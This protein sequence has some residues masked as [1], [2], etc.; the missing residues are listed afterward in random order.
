MGPPILLYN[1]YRVSFP[2]VKR[3]G[4]G[5]DHIPPSSAQVKENVELYLYSLS[6]LSWPVLLP[7]ILVEEMCYYNPRKTK[8][9]ALV[10][11]NAAQISFLVV[12]LK[13]ST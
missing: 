6:G 10:R 4:L 9:S 13:G 2:G 12:L 7:F 1:G 11:T 5:V 8:I 3:Q